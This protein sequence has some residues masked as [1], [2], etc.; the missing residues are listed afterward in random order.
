MNELKEAI[1][2]NSLNVLMK[3]PIKWLYLYA[4]D[5]SLRKFMNSLTRD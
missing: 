1:I 3:R 2:L 4:S 5:S